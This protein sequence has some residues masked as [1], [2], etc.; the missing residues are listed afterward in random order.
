MEFTIAEDLGT[1]TAE[2]LAAKIKEGQ[3]LLAALF[4]AESPTPADVAKAKDISAKVEKLQGETTARATAADDMKAL[5]AKSKVEASDEGGESAEAKAAREAEEAAAREAE[6]AKAK[7]AEE[8]AAEGEKEKEAVTASARERLAGTKPSGATGTTKPAATK[9]TITAAADVPAFS[10]GSKLEGLDEVVDAV[11]SRM[12]A[13]PGPAGIEGGQMHRYGAAIFRKE[14]GEEFTTNGNNDQDV[15]DAAGKEARLPGGNLIAAGGWCAPSETLYDLCEGETT[16]GLLDLPEINVKRG[17]IRTTTGPD[18]ASIYAAGFTQTEAQAIAG[19]VKTCY[20]VPCPTFTDTRLD[21]MGICI[22]S[23]ILQ[24]VGYPELL[25]RVVSGG[26]IAHQH[27]VSAGL[28][29]K[30]VTAAGT[31]VF[32]GNVQSTTSNVG[33][34]LAIIAEGIRESYRLGVNETLEVVF[35]IWVKE[36]IRADLAQR[37]GVDLKAVTDAEIMAIFTVRK[38]RPQFVYNWQMLV[39][40][41]TTPPGTYRIGFPTTV[42]MLVYPAGTFVKGGTDVISLDAVY[43]AASLSTNDYT[44]LFFEEGV[45]LAQRCYKARLITA[46]IVSGGFTGGQTAAPA[47]VAAELAVQLVP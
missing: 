20:T 5:A 39:E 24:N 25:R 22:K 17:G 44:A 12:G 46:N 36:A 2:E 3:D 13:F 10:T 45:L 37:N 19:T 23:P 33:N 30:M 18:F 35:P 1:Y 15:L 47:G 43:D 9:I 6:E 31:Q 8:A 42:Q 28:I 26:L 29:Q 40:P 4:S 27:R 41:A 11:M 21:A 34:S 7:E 16:D 32:A 38:V 14:F